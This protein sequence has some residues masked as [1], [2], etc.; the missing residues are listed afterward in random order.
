MSVEP[1]AERRQ[2]LVQ[3]VIRLG[4]RSLAARR[5]GDSDDDGGMDAAPSTP[6]PTPT[7]RPVSRTG[8]PRLPL[9]ILI[10]VLA[11]ALAAAWLAGYRVNPT[12]AH[13][14]VPAPQATPDE[15]VR[16]FFDAYNHRDFSTVAELYPAQPVAGFIPRHRVLGTMNDL[17]IISSARDTTYGADSPYWAVR[18]RLS[19]S[20]LNGTDLSYV[21]GPTGWTYYLERTGHDHAWRIADH[22]NG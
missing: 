8:G 20:G 6:T 5:H 22:G 15:V 2:T 17:Q 16:T 3:S 19:V 10:G 18:M 4:R 9:V 14:P 7:T 11:V 12:T 1:T 13:V 21:D